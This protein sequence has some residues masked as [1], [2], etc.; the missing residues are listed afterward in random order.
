MTKIL[1]LTAFS[2][3]LTQQVLANYNCKDSNG[4]TLTVNHIYKDAATMEKSDVTATFTT[5]DGAA[6]VF[7]GQHHVIA[8]YMLTNSNGE[9]VGL[10]VTQVHH[11]GGRC[12]RCTPD[13]GGVTTYA[14]LTLPQSEPL[15]FTCQ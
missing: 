7:E 11:Y 10:D 14:K 5:T 8:G 15:T 3:L 4:D 1:A 2:F 13:L 9:A 12:G 6:Q